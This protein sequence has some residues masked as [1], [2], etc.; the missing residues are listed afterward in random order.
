[1][2]KSKKP[3]KIGIDVGGT[4][5][6]FGI[7]K[8]NQVTL[9][10]REPTIKDS[11]ARFINNI[12]TKINKIEKSFGKAEKIGFAVAGVINKNKI[13]KSPNISM[14]D[15][16]AFDFPVNL[17][18]DARAAGLAEFQKGALKDTKSSLLLTLG[19][20]IGG[21]VFLDGKLLA[22][23]NNIIGEVG[24][25]NLSSHDEVFEWEKRASGRALVNLAKEM[26]PNAPF[27]KG[28]R[29]FFGELKKGNK[30]AEKVL[31]KWVKY[32][33]LG[34]SNLILF[35]NPEVIAFGGG[36]S[37][38]FELFHSLLKNAVSDI[39]TYKKAM[40]KLVK[41]KFGNMAGMLGS[42]L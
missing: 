2:V 30:D 33:A 5:T 42:V 20:G 12:I 7:V 32:L 10:Y 15:G 26:F 17:V 24:H 8:N 22:G 38:D 27:S 36:A 6:K 19:T 16:F 1:M 40:P 37:E 14:L 9:L 18:N 25:M 35:Y 28:V 31:K 21:S 11:Q 34:V 41:A 4:H 13:I 23:K 3:V 39:I 29:I